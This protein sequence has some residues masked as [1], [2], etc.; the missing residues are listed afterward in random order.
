MGFFD[1]FTDD[2]QDK[3]RKERK[4]GLDTEFAADNATV[5]LH[6]EKLD[7]NK[8]RVRTGEVILHKDVI[9]EQKTIEVPVS[10]EQVVIERRTFEAEPTNETITDEDSIHIPVSAD[11][12]EVDKYT[13]V[14]GEVSAHKRD[15][16]ETQVV[17][18]V[19]QKEVADVEV[20]GDAEIV[21]KG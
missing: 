19:L 6:E 14:T 11:R 17:Q 3:Q 18:D 8:D 21:N 2:T 5:R 16:E 4:V 7:I 12:V 20:E 15:V 1:F 10:H 13:V 9:E